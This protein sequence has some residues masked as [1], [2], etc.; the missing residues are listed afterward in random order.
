[1]LEQGSRVVVRAE[2]AEKQIVFTDLG[3]ARPAAFRDEIRRARELWKSGRDAEAWTLLRELPVRRELFASDAEHERFRV[4]WETLASAPRGQMDAAV[5]ATFEELIAIAAGLHPATAD[6]IAASVPA[7]LGEDDRYEQKSLDSRRI[8]GRD[9]VAIET[10]R[11][12]S[13]VDP[14][15][16]LIVLDGDRILAMHCARCDDEA[17]A[18]VA[19]SLHFAAASRT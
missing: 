5:G 8:D 9:A 10:W 19:A 3:P 11:K 4:P 12:L 18:D 6:S 2:S 13:H 7:R 14:R 1:M 17:F 15:R 16:Y